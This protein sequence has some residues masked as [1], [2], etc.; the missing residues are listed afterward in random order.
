MSVL[1][2]TP[3]VST[4]PDSAVRLTPLF[5]VLNGGLV[6]VAPTRRRRWPEDSKDLWLGRVVRYEDRRI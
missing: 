5:D 6:T 3:A 2:V 4:P 1:I